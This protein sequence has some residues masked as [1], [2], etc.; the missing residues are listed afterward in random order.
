VTQVKPSAGTKVAQLPFQAGRGEILSGEA[1]ATS[2]NRG[3]S[4]AA[5]AHTAA[6]PTILMGGDA[7][8]ESALL[9]ARHSA[10]QPLRVQMGSTLG[11]RFEVGGAEGEFRGAVFAGAGSRGMN[12]PSGPESWHGAGPGPAVLPHGQAQVPPEERGGEMT[13]AEPGGSTVSPNSAPASSGPSG[14]QHAASPA[15]GHH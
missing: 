12:A 10:H 7:A 6:P 9:G 15:G 11:G 2:F 5:G 3:V 13:R 14:S 1:L 8:K 4:S